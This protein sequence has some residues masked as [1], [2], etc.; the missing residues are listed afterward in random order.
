MLY[1]DCERIL[2]IIL[3][4]KRYVD[5]D[6]KTILVQSPDVDVVNESNYIYQ[7]T[8]E[9][10]QDSYSKESLQRNLISMGLF[11]LEDVEF[12]EKFPHTLKKI[13]KEY[14]YARDNAVRYKEVKKKL[15]SLRENYVRTT[16]LLASYDNYT[17]EYVAS[18]AKSYFILSKTCF[19]KGKLVKYSK[20]LF[21]KIVYKMYQDHIGQD[22]IRFISR[23]NP[24]AN[25]WIGLKNNGVIFKN[26]V[27]LTVEQQ[28][29]LMWTRIYDSLLECSEPPEKRVI[30]DDDM[31]D[32]W[33]ASRE[34]KKEE[35]EQH[36]EVF[37]VAESQED[38]D[39]INSMN[40]PGAKMVKNQRLN[41]VHSYGEVKEA[42]LPDVSQNLAIQSVK[43]EM[44]KRRGK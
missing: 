33:M 5:I 21:D 20:S 12:V 22:Q 3:S 8:L 44:D 25:M 26:G 28:G 43:M 19:Y 9:K 32:G 23:N 41:Y 38:I 37:C 17:Q 36:S 4:G 14:Y 18:T 29:L 31:F 42:E 6:K 10:A 13:Q 30:D 40:S 39:R 11:S 34:D 16:N 15:E 35:K 1:Q 24:W 27:S 7:K 2:Y